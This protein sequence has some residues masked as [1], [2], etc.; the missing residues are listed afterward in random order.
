MK[1]GVKLIEWK[2][3]VLPNLENLE[4]IMGNVTVN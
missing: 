2:Y 4:K 1:N 3:N